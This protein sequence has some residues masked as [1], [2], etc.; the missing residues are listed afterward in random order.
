MG[1]AVE[2]NGGRFGKVGKVERGGVCVCICDICVW[3]CI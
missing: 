1:L 3:F 2:V